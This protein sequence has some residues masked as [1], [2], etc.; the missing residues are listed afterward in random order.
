MNSS[1][2][3][4]GYTPIFMLMHFSCP[5]AVGEPNGGQATTELITSFYTCLDDAIEDAESMSDT[6]KVILKGMRLHVVGDIERNSKRM[7]YVWGVAKS[8][9][10]SFDLIELKL[11]TN[12]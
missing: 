4:N 8:Y 3:F 9:G 1:E 6:D 10:S 11:S 12:I 2:I 7:D 5:Y